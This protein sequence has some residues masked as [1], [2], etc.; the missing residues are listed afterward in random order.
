MTS[1]INSD[2]GND[3]RSWAEIERQLC[4][5]AEAGFTHI[6][7]IHDWSGDYMYSPSE[8]RRASRILK[9]LHLNA[10]SLHATEGCVRVKKDPDGTIHFLHQY[11]HPE[12][13]K[14]Y[15]SEDEELREAGVSLLRNRI[16]M[17][18][19][20]GAHAMV[21]H[22]QLPYKMFL[23]DPSSKERYF[24]Q[25]CKSFAEV[26]NAAKTAGVRI[27]L[28]NLPGTPVEEILDS[29]KRVFHAFG[30]GFMG[31]CYDSGHATLQTTHDP[32]IFLE[33]FYDRLFA[34][35]LQDNDSIAQELFDVDGQ[36]IVHDKHRVPFTGVVNWE[37]IAAYVAKSPIE[38]PADLEV[39][40]SAS[41]EEEEMEL[42][43]DCR[44]RAERFGKMVEDAKRRSQERS[45]SPQ[46]PQ[47][48]TVS[49]PSSSVRTTFP[50][51]FT[52]S[53]E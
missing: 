41:S 7:W 19:A 27:A 32:L 45:C 33:L 46:S 10:H 51:S 13:R 28:E 38:L 34:T 11:R 23:K 22:M 42:L 36:V 18:E 44:R 17:C 12:Y 14:D 9:D 29:F 35:H 4:N 30:P 1:S 24:E 26:E 49:V 53:D 8:M 3:I 6:Q 5:I 37:G 2:Y 21:L 31:M 39:G 40:I 52:D 48:Q 50:S 25:V 15:T 16:D 43:R 20:I 47:T